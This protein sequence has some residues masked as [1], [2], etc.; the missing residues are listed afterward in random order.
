LIEN[1]FQVAGTILRDVDSAIMT[2]YIVYNRKDEGTVVIATI[3]G[4]KITGESAKKV[5]AV[6][7]QCGF[8]Q[9]APDVILHG[10]RVFAVRVPDDYSVPID[11]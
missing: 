11:S 7:F 1:L 3:D 6:L 10:M 4:E 9:V 2:K 8:P 5:K